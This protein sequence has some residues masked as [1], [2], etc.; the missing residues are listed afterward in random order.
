MTVGLLK[1]PPKR[2]TFSDSGGDWGL[3]RK[4]VQRHWCCAGSRSRHQEADLFHNLKKILHV[5]MFELALWELF[6]L[7]E[8][9]WKRDRF[10]KRAVSENKTSE[11]YVWKDTV[12]IYIKITNYP[13][14]SKLKIM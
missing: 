10:P 7:K 1:T 14:T 5:G 4:E 2:D 11:M 8:T 9:L 13:L 6:K 3:W 12:F